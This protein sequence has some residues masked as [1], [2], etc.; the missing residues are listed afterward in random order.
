MTRV[1][2]AVLICL[3]ITVSLT[4]VDARH[5]WPAALFTIAFASQAVLFL[6]V[7]GSQNVERMN[8]FR[9]SRPR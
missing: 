1:G 2:L 4:A 6:A 8:P 5:E 9:R 7:S 3:A